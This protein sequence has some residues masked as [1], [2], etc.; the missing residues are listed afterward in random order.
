MMNM[1][2]WGWL[3]ARR[4]SWM[5]AAAIAMASACDADSPDDDGLAQDHP[6]SGGGATCRTCGYKNSP[7]L[8]KFALDAFTLPTATAPAE[9]LQLVGIVDPGG[10]AATV[11]ID[12]EAFFAV[13][14]GVTYGGAQLE[15][16]SL[17]FASG[18]GE[19]FEVEIAVASGVLDW[20]TG[21]TVPSYTLLYRDP[22]TPD[23]DDNVCPGVNPDHPSIVLISGERYDFE[24]KSVEPGLPDMVTLA[25]HGHAIAKL[26]MLGYGPNDDAGA[27]P[28]QRQ[29]A[30]KMLTADYC[31]KGHSF[32]AIGQPLDWHDALDTFVSSIADPSRLEAKWTDAGASCLATPRLVKRSE[33]EK[34]C[35]AL[36]RC[37]GTLDL[38]GN[39]WISLNP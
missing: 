2:S 1:H 18:T 27:T 31:G 14:G 7:M 5:M 12:D 4:A 15:G 17:V 13:S 39:D 11:K 10:Q 37:N 36:P 19:H 22:A 23:G 32:T 20:A 9:G 38:D 33:V 8:G 24:T 21:A 29:A 34:E 35:P 25:C 6:R 3:G 26:R 16:W 30:L 28:S